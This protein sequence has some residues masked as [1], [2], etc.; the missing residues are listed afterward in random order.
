ML[1]CPNSTGVLLDVYNWYH[2]T[3][4]VWPR[5]YL[6]WYGRPQNGLLSSGYGQRALDV[7]IMSR[8]WMAM[9]S[10][11]W[12][13]VGR[14]ENYV[15]VKNIMDVQ[16]LGLLVKF[17]ANFGLLVSILGTYRTWDP[18]VS[19]PLIGRQSTRAFCTQ[20]GRRSFRRSF[21]FRSSCVRFQ[22]WIILVEVFSRYFLSHT[23]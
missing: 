2:T 19:K 10:T 15:H 14:S 22:Q 1:P 7:H 17:T 23:R 18:L 13:S 5:T 6:T 3:S 20:S 16:K 12:T 21:A 4:I 9:E 8:K 11:L